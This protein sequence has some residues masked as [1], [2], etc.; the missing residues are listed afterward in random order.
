M[1]KVRRSRHLILVLAISIFSYLIFFYPVLSKNTVIGGSDAT[2]LHYPSRYYLAEKLAVNEFPFYTER[3]FSGFPIYADFERAYLNPVNILSIFIFGPFTS[4]KVLHFSFYLIGSLSL[5]LFLKNKKYDIFGFFATNF[6][7]YFS[8]FNLFHQQHFNIVLSSYLLP[9]GIWLIDLFLKTD[10][11]RYLLYNALFIS[12]LIYFGSLQ[13]IILILIAQFLYILVNKKSYSKNLQ[14]IKALL[15]KLLLMFGFI[16]AFTLPQIVPALNL[17]SQS[18][19]LEKKVSYTQGSYTPLMAVNIVYPY[20]FGL[21][22]EYKGIMISDEYQ[23]HETYIYSGITVFVIGIVAILFLKNSEFKT[24]LLLLFGVFLILGFIGFI[25]TIRNLNIPILAMFRY[26][27]RSYM[28][29]NFGLACLVGLFI[30]GLPKN[31]AKTIDSLKKIMDIRALKLLLGVVA[32]FLLIELVNFGNAK[33]ITIIKLILGGVVSFDLNFMLWGFFLATTVLL[34]YLILFHFHHINSKILKSKFKIFPIQG[35][36]GKVLLCALIVFD[37]G[38]FSSQVAARYF[39]Q[40]N[41]IFPKEISNLNTLDGHKNKRVIFYDDSNSWNL[42]LYNSAWSI[43]GYSQFLPDDYDKYL[44]GFGFKNSKK[45][46]VG[47]DLSYVTGDFLKSTKALGVSSVFFENSDDFLIENYVVDLLI[48]DTKVIPKYI[49]KEEGHIKL[50]ILAE[51]ATTIET[52]VRNYEGWQLKVNG[53]VESF[54]NVKN[55]LYLDFDLKKGESIVELKYV[56]IHFY[57]GLKLSA[58]TIVGTAGFLIFFVRRKY[59][60]L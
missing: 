17:Y 4:Y 1:N 29:F 26:W 21:D 15:I 24:Y 19:R 11:Y 2:R 50:K 59:I 48:S 30:S 46:F 18:A 5:Y 3:I 47:D 25:P 12:I 49:T 40:L 45:L 53:K 31:L 16:I 38:F 41:E 9:L 34:V 39:R 43:F 14:E 33:T 44:K 42:S 23:I 35:A 57:D 60:K 6:I 32:Y 27:S 51:N 8:F 28:L 52:L 56:P 13:T 10:R 54:S 20:F 36:L 58:V 22:A 7:Y 37:L 55:D